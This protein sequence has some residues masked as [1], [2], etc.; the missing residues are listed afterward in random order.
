M[1]KKWKTVLAK[2]VIWLAA[3]ILL[4]FVGI[5]D[6]ADYSEF[7]FEKHATILLLG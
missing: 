3:E 1:E 4:N 6:M 7:I 2:T 5:D